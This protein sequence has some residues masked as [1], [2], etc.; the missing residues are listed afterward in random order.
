ME[1][2]LHTSTCQDSKILKKDKDPTCTLQDLKRAWVLQ[3][4]KDQRPT[5][6]LE[7]LR[8]KSPA[9]TLLDLKCTLLDLKD[10][11]N[12]QEALE[13]GKWISVLDLKKLAEAAQSETGKIKHPIKEETFDWRQINW[14][15]NTKSEQ[16]LLVVQK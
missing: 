4:L 2:N 12:I 9:C 11:Q 3:D 15:E 5:W 16:F 8:D 7:D 10:S 14:R 6:I 1:E 13:N